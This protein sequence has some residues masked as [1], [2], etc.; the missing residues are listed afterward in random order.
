MEVAVDANLPEII[1]F[2]QGSAKPAPAGNM[3]RKIHH[4]T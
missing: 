4:G 2:L 3:E 1:R